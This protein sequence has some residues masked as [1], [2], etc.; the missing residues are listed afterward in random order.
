[1]ERLVNTEKDGLI[2]VIYTDKLLIEQA[3]KGACGGHDGR[4][5]LPFQGIYRPPQVP[6]RTRLIC[7]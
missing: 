7:N 4:G 6:L 1:M 2:K 3:R 5:K